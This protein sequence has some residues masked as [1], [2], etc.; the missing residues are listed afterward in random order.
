MKP[1]PLPPESLR[2]KALRLLQAGHSAK[3]IAMALSIPVGKIYYWKRYYL[4]PLA[5]QE[6]G[7]RRYDQEFKQTVSKQL[8]TGGSVSQ[9]AQTLG[10]SKVTLFKWKKA[11]QPVSEDVN[12]SRSKDSA[13]EANQAHEPGDKSFFVIQ[14]TMKNLLERVHAL[15]LEQE[16]LKQVLSSLQEQLRDGTYPANRGS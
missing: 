11:W 15:E 7:R 13:S 12:E 1:Q 2:E 5:L 16:R 4:N 3:Q 14:L 10:V 8:A 6:D 9:L